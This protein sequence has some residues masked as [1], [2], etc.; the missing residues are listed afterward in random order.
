MQATV[1]DSLPTPRLIIGPQELTSGS[2]G[3]YEHHD[4]ATGNVQADVPLA[5]AADVDAAVAAARTAFPAWRD[6]D[7][8]RRRDILLEIAR[9]VLADQER[10]AAIATREM[11]MPNALAGTAAHLAADWFTYYAGWIG[12]CGGDVVPVPAGDAFDYVRDEP[13]G[14]IGA[15]I[16]WNGPLVSIGMKVAPALAAGNCVVLKP[17]ENAPFTALR[18]A[19]IAADAGLPP[20][21]FNVIPGTGEAGA[22]LCAHPGVDKITFTGG[23]ETARKVLTAAAQALTPVTLELGG[24]SANIVFPDADL[25]AA[26]AM[27]IGAGL[28]TLSGQGCMLPTRLLVHNDIYDDVVSRVTAGAQLL[29]VGDPWE[30][31]T[32]MGP[33]ATAAQLERVSAAVDSAVRDGSGTL[34]GGGAR[35]SGLGSGYFYC[36]TVFGDVDPASDLAQKEIFGPVLSILRFGSDDEAVQLANDTPYG[37]A[38]YVH[39]RDLRRAHVLAAALDAGGVA[40][41]GFPIVPSGAPFG[42]VKQSGFGREGGIWGLREFQRTKNVYIGLQ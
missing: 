23:G 33:L 1:P 26:V 25:D 35:P 15:I 3:S 18:F 31:T 7:L 13:L 21:V 38:A 39:T 32:V 12:K 40:V 24:K 8:N 42:G 19:E 10:L 37:L 30:P 5:G 14:V 36:P 2:G 20:G 22:A 6:L 27:A 28:V 4:P 34:L 17:P 41:N 29:T 11:G 16:P 9:K